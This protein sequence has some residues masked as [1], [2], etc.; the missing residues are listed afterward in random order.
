MRALVLAV[1]LS[2][3]LPSAADAADVVS[4]VSGATVGSRPVFT[5]DFARGNAR[6]EFSRAADVKTAGDEA[7]SFVESYADD[8]FTI[9]G[10]FSE[11]PPYVFTPIFPDRLSAG[12]YFW[13]VRAD[14]YADDGEP[15]GGA[16]PTWGPIRTLTVRDE[17][18][19]FEGWTIR[20]QRLRAR[21]RCRSRLR[22]RGTIAWSDNAESPT[23]RYGVTLSA[24]GRTLG[25]VG[26]E[27]SEFSRS[28]DGIIC[29][30]RATRAG[31]VQAAVALR[32]TARQITAGPRRTVSVG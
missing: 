19:L 14:D 5:F 1:T 27:L 32:D 20:V 9:G 24:A 6:V 15:G 21:G 23:V 25:R 17:P 8:S 4:P 22:A 11:G 28:F 13:H 7:G 29:A 10:E 16:K 12:R 30:R 2:A 26:G 3:F 18:A 31:R